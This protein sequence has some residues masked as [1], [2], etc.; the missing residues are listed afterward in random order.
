MS[1]D[2]SRVDWPLVL[3]SFSAGVLFLGVV[4]LVVV[5]AHRKGMTNNLYFL[6]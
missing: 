6:T 5:V 3:G 2:S 4:A 1:S